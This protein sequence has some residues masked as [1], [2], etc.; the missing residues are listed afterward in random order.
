M[1][2]TIYEILVETWNQVVMAVEGPSTAISIVGSHHSGSTLLN[3]CLD[4]HSSV[5]GL[6]EVGELETRNHDEARCVCGA[7]I[8]QCEFW[9]DITR[10]LAS[11]RSVSVDSFWGHFSISTV[12]QRES[13]SNRY[14]PD[15]LEIALILG[16][17]ALC[18][19]LESWSAEIKKHVQ[20]IRNSWALFD[21]VCEKTGDEYVVDSA[22]SPI[23]MKLLHL[24]RPGEVRVIYLIRDGRAVADSYMRRY[25]W[26]PQR[27]ARTWWREHRNTLLTL[28][29]MPNAVIHAVKY[30]EFCR[31][32]SNN[33]KKICDFLGLRFEERMLE[34]RSGESHQVG[35]NLMRY[36]LSNDEI[37]YRDG[38]KDRLNQQQVRAIENAAYGAVGAS[39]RIFGY[40]ALS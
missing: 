35:G 20:S 17:G 22:K 26:S 31:E 30:D 36:D 5:T 8:A 29:T 9:S 38:W 39:N 1:V 25:G 40:G 12:H 28:M 11:R 34:F 19:S 15:P 16:S 13:S 27:A 14:L 23:R 10:R 3:F 4:S 21:A 33:L 18:R 32:P 24:L 2:S 7:T 37:E 6:G